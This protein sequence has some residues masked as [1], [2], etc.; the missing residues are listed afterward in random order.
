MRSVALAL[1][2]SLRSRWMVVVAGVF[3]MSVSG[4]IYAFGVY[5]A[6]LKRALN[7]NQKTLTTIGFF[8]D[9][10]NIGI[11]AGIIADLCPA[12][13]V[14][15]IGVA[16]NSVGYLMIWL[17]MTHR[18]RAPALWQMFVYITIGGNSVAFTHSGALVTCV[19][20]FPLH[21]GMIVG[22]L[23]GFLGLSTAILSLF[24][25]AIYGDHP[26]SFVL[27]IVY[28][29]LA[30]ILSFM[31][32]IRPLPVP[33]GGKIED[34]ARVFY[35]LLAF[36]LLVAGYLMLV[37]LVQHSVKLDKAV[38]GGLAGLLALLLCIP[39]AMVVA[40]ELRK[41]RA[42]KPV[43]DVESS[44]D[45][46]GDK[47]GGPILDGAYG[48]GSK[49]RDKALA[50]VEPRESSEE[51]ETVTVPLEAPPPAAVPEAAPVL[52]RRSIVQ[53]AGELFKTPPIG[54]DFTVWQAL[55][56]L[57]FWLLSAASTAGLG[58]GLMLIDN[59]GQIGSSY[60]YDAERTNTFVSL[61]SIWNCL[62]RVGSGFV[63]EYFVQRYG[64][65]RPFFFALA[66]GL[67]AIGY[68]TIALDL[69]GALFVGSILIG[70]CFGAQWALLHIIISEI[71]G[72]KY[73]GTLQSII[74]MASPLGTYLLSV[75]VAGY[76]YDREA[77]RQLPR[78]TAESCHGT[79][80]YRTSLLIM[81][82]VCCAGCLLTLVITL[83]TRRFYKREVFETLKAKKI[84]LV[85]AKKASR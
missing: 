50:K 35:R 78:G 27:L 17:A 85:N 67:S 16:F 68:L 55:V 69:P 6:A 3:I 52:R 39:F 14:L 60:G 80:C 45:E 36:E 83:R 57:D 84:E 11:F 53:R 40:M 47:A 28:L 22:L 43:V 70:L 71:Y 61:T 37:I 15:S 12:W 23:K 48:G 65:A 73:Y 24:Y 81:C 63:S 34:E 18:T 9:F 59:L 2:N 4:S 32:F 49:D 46:G 54:S 13:V 62:G 19:K 8:K 75:R 56:H 41:L 29:P 33:S 51:D 77:A 42:E 1:G 82:G 72:L 38:N 74:A 31:F 21:R 26:S 79:V 44:K 25:R 20:N 7:Y 10:G 5:S 58:A 64:L 30:V 76:M 66:L